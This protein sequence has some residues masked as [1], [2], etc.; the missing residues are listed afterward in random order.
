MLEYGVGPVEI[1]KCSLP[2]LFQVTTLNREKIKS[3]DKTNRFI[4]NTLNEK[5]YFTSYIYVKSYIFFFNFVEIC[6]FFL[7]NVS[8]LVSVVSNEDV[9]MEIP[10]NFLLTLP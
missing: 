1:R 7:Y 4:K 5:T 10:Y 8:I 9:L 2:V 3:F 6:L